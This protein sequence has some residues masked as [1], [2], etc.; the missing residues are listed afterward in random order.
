MEEEQ[1]ACDS[2]WS[3]A[4]LKSPGQMAPGLPTLDV[5]KV[6]CSDPSSAVRE[7][8]QV[9]LFLMTLDPDLG[10]EFLPHHPRAHFWR[11]QGCQVQGRG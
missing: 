8:F 10:E 2:Y 7:E 3:R 4:I 1:E 6:P 5:G 11:G 9:F